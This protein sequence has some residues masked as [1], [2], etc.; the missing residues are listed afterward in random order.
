[1]TRLSSGALCSKWLS[2]P[3]TFFG[4]FSIFACSVLPNAI[5]EG[6]KLVGIWCEVSAFVGD[7]HQ[8]GTSPTAKVVVPEV[9]ECGFVVDLGFVGNGWDPNVRHEVGVVVCKDHGRLA[10]MVRLGTGLVLDFSDSSVVLS[11]GPGW[12][13]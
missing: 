1:M 4:M 6:L 5:G 3:K 10:T 2:P 11:H 13:M 8:G 12:I 9:L 7:A